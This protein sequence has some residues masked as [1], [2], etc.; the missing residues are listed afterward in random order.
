M[1]LS[2]A[3]AIIQLTHN[4]LISEIIYTKN[5]FFWATFVFTERSINYK[6]PYHNNTVKNNKQLI[7][8]PATNL[9]VI[10]STNTD[11]T[12]LKTVSRI[13]PIYAR[14]YASIRD[15]GNSRMCNSIDWQAYHETSQGWKS[16]LNEVS[17]AEICKTTGL[18]NDEQRNYANNFTASRLRTPS[19]IASDL[20]TPSRSF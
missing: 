14:K 3:I 17:H 1:K 9:R 13:L 8:P 11:D 12:D 5:D 7:M 19:A 6:A 15:C 4:R 16:P 20:P 10:N 2:R 18:P